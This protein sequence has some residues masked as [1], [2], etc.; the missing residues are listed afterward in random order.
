VLRCAE[1]LHDVG[2]PLRFPQQGAQE[3]KPRRARVNLMC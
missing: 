2:P 1:F 3:Q